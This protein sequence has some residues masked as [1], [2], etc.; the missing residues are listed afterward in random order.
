VQWRICNY[1]KIYWLYNNTDV[2]MHIKLR[3]LEW[4]GHICRM[5]ISRAPR[6][7]LEGDFNGSQPIGKPKER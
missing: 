5:D 7:R 3:R 6:E 2:L 4:A 1:N